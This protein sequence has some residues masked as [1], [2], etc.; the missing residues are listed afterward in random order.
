MVSESSRRVTEDTKIIG[1]NI[2]Q[3]RRMRGCTQEQL[4][5]AMSVTFQQVQ[6]YE[7]GQSRVSAEKLFRLQR[8]LSVPYSAFFSGISKSCEA[9]AVQHDVLAADIVRAIKAMPPSE[10]NR[11]LLGLVF[12]LVSEA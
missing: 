5:Q 1:S 10:I 11:K 3:L 4:A 8:F 12:L 7:S 9:P 6:K 2:L